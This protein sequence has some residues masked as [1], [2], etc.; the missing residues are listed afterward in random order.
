MVFWHR[1][2]H[3]ALWSLLLLVKHTKAVLVLRCFKR[4]MVA[5]HSVGRQF[6]RFWMLWMSSIFLL[7]S[8]VYMHN[9]LYIW[10]KEYL[11]LH[12]NILI[13]CSI[14]LLI[15]KWLLK[16]VILVEPI[17]SLM[18]ATVSGKVQFQYFCSHILTVHSRLLYWI[19]HSFSVL[20]SDNE[21][22][23][24]SSSSHTWFRNNNGNAIYHWLLSVGFLAFVNPLVLL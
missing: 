22:R 4:P 7:C 13:F 20:R 10:D 5:T 24:H 16:V 14:T 12:T 1:N 19:C 23:E 8:Y 3:G 17:S 15:V 18:V 21:T 11:L 6:Y 2:L 9:L